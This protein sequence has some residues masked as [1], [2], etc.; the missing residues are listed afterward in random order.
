MPH[1]LVVASQTLTNQHLIDAAIARN[2]EEPCLFTL[3]ALAVTQKAST[4]SG[5]TAAATNVPHFGS[6]GVDGYELARHQLGLAK[7]L[8]S[9][10]GLRVRGEVGDPDPLAAVE[11]VLANTDVAVDEI[12]ISTL[13]STVSHWLRMD[14]PSKLRRRFQQPVVVVTERG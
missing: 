9:R 5:L 12:M 2:A 1:V 13:P 14:V 4:M 3:L 6:A 11:K 10:A 7:Q 8:F